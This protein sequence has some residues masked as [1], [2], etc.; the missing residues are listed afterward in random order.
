MLLV[1][2]HLACNIHCLYCYEKKYR[3]IHSPKMDYDLDLMLRRMEELKDVYPDM[4]LHGGEPL[5]LP[6]KD[7]RAL[8]LKMKELTGKS[9][10]QTNGTLIDD[11]FIQIFKECS[12]MVGISHDGPGELSEY[13]FHKLKK[14]PELDKKIKKMIKEGINV[15]IIIVVTKSNAGTPE[16]LRKLKNYILELRKLN[17]SGR[18]NPCGGAKECELDEERL[19][20]VYL[21]LAELYIHNNFSIARW[22]PFT[23][24]INA[25]QNKPRV[26]TFMGCDPFCTPSAAELLGDGA[27]TNCMR[28]NQSCLLLRHPIKMNTRSEILSQTPQEFGGC[29]GCKYWHACYG[30]CPTMA[31]DNDWRNRTYQ[32]SLWYA[33]F[34]F[35]EKILLNC[36]VKIDLCPSINITTCNQT[37]PEVTHIDHIDEVHSDGPIPYQDEGHGDSPHLDYIDEAHNDGF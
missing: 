21:E 33:L 25:L 20:Q 32:C 11:D 7:V 14:N 28:T 23:E 29:Q 37:D 13:R 9:G 22:S 12:T 34:E 27:I 4:C 1:I 8:L 3:K 18:I 5:M 10:I 2:P 24:I 30:G 16:R 19:K 36:D 6:K 15:A 17:I 31:I 26:C 35:Y